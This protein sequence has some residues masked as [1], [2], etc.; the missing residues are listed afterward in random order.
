[1]HL[2]H[3][4]ALSASAPTHLVH[5]SFTA[6][7][8]QELILACNTSLELYRLH[9]KSDILE[10]VLRADA[11][12]QIR[13]VD[14]FRLPG[15]RRDFLVVTSDSGSLAILSADPASASFK[16]VHC[17]PFGKSGARR[18]V[19]GAYLA[20]EPHG[21]ACMVAALEK[22]K[23]AYVLNRDP[24][25]N[26][27]ISSPLEAHKSAIVTHALVSLDVGFENP[28][29]AALERSYEAT[30]RKLLVYYELDLGLNQVIRKMTAEV[31]HDSALLLR[32]PGGGDGPGGVLVCSEGWVS[33]RNLLEE[34]EDGRLLS[35]KNASTEQIAEKGAEELKGLSAERGAGAWMEARLPHRQGSD[36]ES[37]MVVAGTAY[38]DRKRNSFFFLLCSE[39]GDL[40]KAE[41]VWEPDR[42]VTGL[43]LVYFDSLP[44]PVVAMCIFRSGYLAAVVEGSDS[45]LLRFRE[46]NVSGDDPS[47]GFSF[48]EGSVGRDGDV[49]GREDPNGDN[50]TTSLQR[51]NGAPAAPGSSGDCERQSTVSLSGKLQFRPR[52]LLSHLAVVSAIDSFGPILS[53]CNVG[54]RV[55]QSSSLICTTGRS[56]R[57]S[58]RVVRRGMGILEMSQPH[59]LASKL[60][61]VF[62]CK[63]RADTL[64]HRL[65]VVS[66]ETRTKVLEVGEAKVEETV[67]SGF[68]LGERT[69]SAGQM[70]TNSFVQVTRGGVRFIRGG[71][72]GDA[73]EWNPPVPAVIVAGCC[74]QQQVVVVL[75]TGAIVYFEID[76]SSGSLEELGKNPDAMKWDEEVDF[77]GASGALDVGRPSVAIPDIPTGRKRS[78]FFAAGDGVSGKVRLFQIS[79]DA[80]I[81]ALGL[82]IAPAP[83]E[84]IAFVDFGC[85]D[86]DA[87]ATTMGSSRTLSNVATYT[88]FLILVLGTRHGAL[89]RLAVD[90]LT[91]TLSSKR[92]TFIGENPVHV[93]HVRIAGIP[94]CVVMGSSTWILFLRGGQATMSPLCT[95][96]MEHAAAFSLEH[97]PDGFVVTYGS[98]LRLLSLEGISALITCAS[99]PHGLPMVSVPSSTILDSSF[100]VARSRTKLTPRRVVRVARPRSISSSHAERKSANRESE[101]IVIIETDYNSK[102]IHKTPS[103]RPVGKPMSDRSSNL[104]LNNAR[105]SNWNSRLQLARILD[106]DSKTDPDD[107]DDVD[108]EGTNP[109]LNGRP[110]AFQSLDTVQMRDNE[111]ILT[112]VSSSSLGR[113]TSETLSY[114]VV[115][116]VANLEISGTSP[117]RPER[118]EGRAS[119][120]KNVT[121]SLSVY[122]VDLEAQRLIFLYKTAVGE[123]VH[124]LASFR[125]M[126][127]VGI[128]TAIRLYDLGK[129]QLLRKGEYK[130]AVR[131]KISALAVAGGD[132]IFVGDVSDSVTLFGYLLVEPVGINHAKAFWPGGRGGHFV[133][134]AGDSVPRWVV[135]LTALD[136]NTVAGSDKFG[137]IFIL[138]VPTELGSIG[139]E[140]PL[141]SVPMLEG[142]RAATS[143]VPHKLSVEA[144]YHVGSIVAGFARG[145]MAVKTTEQIEKFDGDEALIYSTLSGTIGILA[146]MHTQSDID[147]ARAL[148]KEMRARH[149]SL[150]GR[151]HTSYRSSFY[152]SK[153]VVDGDLCQLFTGMALADREQCAS[154]LGRSIED[155][156]R[157]LAEL[158][159]SYV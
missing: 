51:A 125:D 128:G 92:S 36:G 113:S 145:S 87:V 134:I 144:S 49:D 37:L 104:H 40:V 62:S 80:S 61:E 78:T 10:P 138:R 117:N 136:Y 102:H 71:H 121:A 91:G 84:S 7:R 23:F 27:T 132:R 159:T 2:Y 101:L 72:A 58:V 116:Q 46:V 154:T 119:D 120:D 48:S 103:G 141:T 89:V 47:G 86:K 43:R 50:L 22:S 32:V 75:S 158:H 123:P 147:F 30:S 153:H 115:S 137:N 149:Q 122:K 59:Q 63:D 42:G 70:D 93:K 12:A 109:L 20:C 77:V 4:T 5:G 11:F 133:P 127:L 150:C 52:S 34:D 13:A 88:P 155:V 31:R 118:G 21:R 139:G 83:I 38:H 64:F 76:S 39:L 106:G 66:F 112:A 148:E 67:N 28:M 55:G 29:F 3:F 135:T 90:A 57:G 82:H 45:L 26:V 140:V 126:L 143:I 130:F 35:L 129:Q 9:P 8:Q 157:K 95:D 105:L 56:G 85:I 33:Y 97:S 146:P 73:S 60:T 114:I 79:E 44:G 19:P 99:L 25:E 16:P 15:T 14:T 98:K 65:I 100:T 81:E 151:D 94:T 142:S 17:E 1:M 152:P 124:C 74:N 41:L 54:G 131:N 68:V 6:P 18:S 110:A 108:L 156:D 107:E 24:D 69:L 53:M 96:P 111:C